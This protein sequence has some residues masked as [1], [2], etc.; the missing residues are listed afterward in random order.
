MRYSPETLKDEFADV[1]F[2]TFRLA[3]LMGIDIESALQQKID[4]IKERT[5]SK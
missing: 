4:K 3:K 1:I 2:V 5:E